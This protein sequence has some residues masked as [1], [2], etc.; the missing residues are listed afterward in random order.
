MVKTSSDKIEQ[1][2]KLYTEEK[3][4]SIKISK[5][6]GISKTTVLEH[7]RNNNILRRTSE[8]GELQRQYT[9]NLDAFQQIDSEISAYVLGFMYADG[10][11][12][13]KDGCI[14]IGIVQEDSEV[15]D[16][17]RKSLDSNH[18]YKITKRSLLNKNHKDT[19]MLTVYSRRI[20]EAF[21][22]LGCFQGKSLT[23]IFPTLEQVPEE[24]Q[25]HFIRGYFDG[26]GYVEKKGRRADFWGTEDFLNSV[27][28]ILETKAGIVNIPP[29]RTRF[30]ERNN[31]TRCMWLQG[32]HRSI[33][34]F[35][36]MYKDANY[37]LTRKKNKFDIAIDANKDKN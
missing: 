22:K 17:I 24:F 6:L 37:F 32:I 33:P 29:L 26:D 13:E 7:L 30:P 16:I 12:N 20:S 10:Y 21:A 34:L 1:I 35:N 15:L 14:Q 4:S 3:L 11:N 31:S 5:Q 8:N 23:L 25:H 36:Y 19:A 9:L 28:L 2:I 18:P 27:K